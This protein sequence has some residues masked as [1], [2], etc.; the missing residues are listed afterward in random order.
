MSDRPYDLIPPKPLDPKQPRKG[1][2]LTTPFATLPGVGRRRGRLRLP[3][4]R[5]PGRAQFRF[6]L[7][8][9]RSCAGGLLCAG[10]FAA[11]LP[12]KAL[13]AE[14][15]SLDAPETETEGAATEEPLKNV[16]GVHSGIGLGTHFLGGKIR[17]DFAFL[18]LYYGRFLEKPT[19]EGKAWQ[20]R[21]ML[22]GEA[23]VG[24]EVRPGDAWVASLTGLVRYQFEGRSSF[25]PFLEAGYGLTWT[26][27]GGP[28]LGGEQQFNGEMGG[29][30]FWFAQPRLAYSLQYRLT[31]YSNAGLRRPNSGVNLNSFLAGVSYF[32]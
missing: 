20:G 26:D 29:G 1:E 9:G 16:I 21:W 15:V 13:A 10:L 5:R 24:R 31:H 6:R 23:T 30:V 17:H 25:V 22:L 4:V 18:N 12:Q 14:V 8:P 28:D 27:L 11:L 19:A 2:T 7:C 32:Y 3:P